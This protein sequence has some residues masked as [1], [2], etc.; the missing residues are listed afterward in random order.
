MR[1]VLTAGFDRA[2]H[3]IALAELARREGHE[4]AAVLV[5]RAMRASRV[6]QLVRQR[7]V[8]SL[9]DAAKRM[10][11]AAAKGSSDDALERFLVERGVSQRS[12]A[13]W[14]SQHGVPHVA[15]ES[16]N[17]PE[18]AESIRASRCDG[19]LYGGGGILKQPFL[20][21]CRGRVLNAHSGPL[22]DVR[23]MNACEW[24]L[25]LGATPSVTIH[26]IDEGID[27]GGVLETIAVEVERGDSIA[28]LRGKCVIAGVEGLLRAMP[29]LSGPLPRRAG[30]AGAS[31]QCF[32]L[33][34]VMRELLEARLA[35]RSRAS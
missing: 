21:A 32:T 35:A 16:L 12:L 25:L 30:G 23:G 14:C 22:P 19:V 8:R 5:V 2:L 10:V 1:V 18:A 6:R 9:F 29:A 33:A 26:V 11:G 13:A 20:E 17:S 27:T 15:V 7:G 24:S 4:I 28:S 31:R 34:P 3:A